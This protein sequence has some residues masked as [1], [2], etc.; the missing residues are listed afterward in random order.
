MITEAFDDQSPAII[1]PRVNEAAPRV[2]ACILTFSHVIEEFVL[3]NYECGQIAS[4]WSATGNTPI[5]CI[6][7][8]GKKFAFYKTFIGAP[9]C[10]ATV[11]D[12]LSEIKTDKYIVFGG[13]GCLNKEIAHG[14][15]M[16]PTQ[17]YRDEGTSYHYAPA[18]DYIRVITVYTPGTDR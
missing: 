4:F 17:A 11:E 14:K 6:D 1:N 18:S 13:A 5:Y 2:D 9:A 3:A 10:V 12:T 16:I 7:H 15:V 8:M